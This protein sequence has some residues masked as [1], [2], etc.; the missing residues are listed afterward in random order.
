MLLTVYKFDVGQRANNRLIADTSQWKKKKSST[1]ECVYVS[2]ILAPKRMNRFWCS[3]KGELF[4]SAYFIQIGAR[5]P[6]LR[7]CEIHIFS[8]A[9]VSRPRY[10]IFLFV[11]NCEHIGSKDQKKV[12]SQE[13]APEHAKS[14]YWTGTMPRLGPHNGEIDWARTNNIVWRDVPTLIQIHRL[15]KIANYIVFH[16]SLKYGYQMKGLN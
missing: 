15:H 6:S 11:L 4:G 7:D 3:L 9:F 5:W 1:S 2:G 8:S 13:H 12:G 10:C 14:K 16:N